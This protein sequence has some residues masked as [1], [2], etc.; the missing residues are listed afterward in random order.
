MIALGGFPRKKTREDDTKFVVMHLKTYN[1]K[2]HAYNYTRKQCG[3]GND[4]QALG[5]YRDSW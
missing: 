1:V 2:G 4:E 5:I 3:S